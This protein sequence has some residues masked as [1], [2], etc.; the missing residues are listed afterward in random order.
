[1]IVHVKVTAPLPRSRYLV[2]RGV[3]IRVMSPSCPY[4]PTHPSHDALGPLHGKRH[5]AQSC[6]AYKTIT[7]PPLTVLIRRMRSWPRRWRACVPWMW[8][9][10]CW[11]TTVVATRCCIDWEAG[12]AGGT[13]TTRRALRC[14]PR[15]HSSPS[16]GSPDQGP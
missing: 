13:W 6:R 7:A 11:W 10:T 9:G 15:Q 3:A 2:G 5:I 1:M 4:R 8:S 12:G 16:R 14:V